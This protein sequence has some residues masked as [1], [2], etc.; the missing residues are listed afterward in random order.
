MW[1]SFTLRFSIRFGLIIIALL[2]LLGCQSQGVNSLRDMLTRRLTRAPIMTIPFVTEH[3]TRSSSLPNTLE[4]CFTVSPA[5]LWKLGNEAEE[6]QKQILSTVLLV[7]DGNIIL[8][9]NDQ[10]FKVTLPL[11]IVYDEQGKRIGSYGGSVSTCYRVRK[12]TQSMIISV[13][14]TTI[15]GRIHTYSW[16]V[17]PE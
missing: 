6:L 13:S 3:E 17:L 2:S 16:L 10:L 4:V 15:S 14:V 7:V 8:P 11:T 1:L 12:H 9:D 5:T